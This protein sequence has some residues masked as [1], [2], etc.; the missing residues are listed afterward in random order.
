[1]WVGMLPKVTSMRNI[2]RHPDAG[3]SEEKSGGR[4]ETLCDNRRMT[5][6]AVNIPRKQF[7]GCFI[8][9]RGLAGAGLDDRR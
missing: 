5:G 8:D 2:K 9:G 1:M 4:E 6:K 7:R 3:Y